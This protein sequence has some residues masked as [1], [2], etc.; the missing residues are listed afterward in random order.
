MSDTL[1]E[2]DALQPGEG[3]LGENR[4]DFVDT[5]TEDSV[6]IR[7]SDPNL[8]HT[9]YSPH[10]PTYSPE[11][12][13]DVAFERGFPPS[14]P[15]RDPVEIDG[16]LPRSTMPSDANMSAVV[17]SSPPLSPATNP[18]P[19]HYHH[20][21]DD[22][23]DVT[24][25]HPESVNDG[26]TLTLDIRDI[27]AGKARFDGLKQFYN[28]FIDDEGD[29]FATHG[30]QMQMAWGVTTGRCDGSH[31]YWS[32]VRRN[33]RRCNR[34]RTWTDEIL[35]GSS[36]GNAKQYN[37]PTSLPDNRFSP[38]LPLLAMF[39]LIDDEKC[40]KP[41]ELPD[42]MPKSPDSLVYEIEKMYS[43]S[44]FLCGKNLGGPNKWC[45]PCINRS[46]V[47]ERLGAMKVM[48][49]NTQLTCEMLMLWEMIRAP[50]WV[51][52][53]VMGKSTSL[54]GVLGTF[55]RNRYVTLWVLVEPK[56][57]RIVIAGKLNP[58]AKPPSKSSATIY[59]TYF[60][61]TRLLNVQDATTVH[62]AFGKPC[63]KDAL[64]GKL[65]SMV[66]EMEEWPN[67]KHAVGD[68]YFPALLLREAG[69]KFRKDLNL[70]RRRVRRRRT[71]N[72][73]RR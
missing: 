57:R 56:N 37:R 14:T 1:N 45:M 62:S 46:S 43:D 35:G 27:S 39:H 58:K 69:K 11:S 26:G 41:P 22:D 17:D 65:R 25:S 67:N 38:R 30:W 34:S 48:K 44:C 73:L 72:L 18:D 50:E 47:T 64:F 5:D 63:F 24:F 36:V 54:E 2:L 6:F 51:K 9:T 21:D 23:T 20:H 13:V 10:S 3:T 49:L 29:L 42:V 31:Y 59:S 16:T 7:D 40:E 52:W 28:A 71:Y 15:R 60:K 33:G 55:M 70:K 4:M 61:N 32:T 66:N 68:T 8:N 19:P 12:P 53:Y